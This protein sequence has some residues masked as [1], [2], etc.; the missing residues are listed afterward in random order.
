MATE[1][2]VRSSPSVPIDFSLS[3]VAR[4]IQLATLFRRR[5]E[6]GQWAVGQ[7]I[8]TV[9]ELAD[10]CAVAR[11]TVRQALDILEADKL[12]ER[13]RAKG[14]FVI[15]KP[16]SQ[17]WCAVPTDLSGLLLAAEGASIELLK[18]E[19]GVMP[20]H[21]QHDI[22]TLA[23]SYTHWR[24]RHSREGQPY[25]IGDAYVD[26][27]LTRRIPKSAFKRHTTM[28]ILRD[29]PGLELKEIDQTLTV[30][31]ADMDLSRMLE[32]PLNAPVA[33]V[34]RTATDKD[35]TVVFVGNGV[36]RGDVVRLDIKVEL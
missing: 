5:I 21:V 17:L 27:R 4:Y 1:I 2:A 32:I 33:H 31:T 11:A 14:T 8:P 9:E 34:Y 3:G 19:K 6:A 12:I 10:E 30:S 15:Q 25:Y 29:L 28:R 24:R 7:Q 18:T 22:G 26:E 20:A 13:F 23:P 36:Y 16:Q 35:G